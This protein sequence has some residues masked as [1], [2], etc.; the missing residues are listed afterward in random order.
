MSD[1]PVPT[2]GGSYLRNDVTGELHRVAGPEDILMEPLP[3][4]PAEEVPGTPPET[5]AQEI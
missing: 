4:P 3:E 5:P 2:A 1:L